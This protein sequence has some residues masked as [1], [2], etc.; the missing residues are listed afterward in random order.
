MAG[1]QID[2]VNNKIDFD[3]DLDTSIS[4]NTDDTLVIEAGGVNIASITAGE[5]AINEGSADV[6]FRVESNGNT[7]M[8]FVDGGN[9]VVGIGTSSPNFPLDVVSDSSANGIQLRG[10]SAD[11]IAQFSFESNDS[12]TTYSQLQSLSS[13][14]KVKTIANIPMSFHTNNSEVFRMHTNGSLSNGGETAPDTAVGLCLNQAGNDGN[15]LTFKSSDVGHGITA[16]AETD[17]YV[18]QR[19]L[20]DGSGGLLITAFSG[21]AVGMKME[22][23]ITGS[24]TAESSAATSAWAVD[25][26]KKNGTN[27]AG[28]STDDNIAS[29]RQSDEAQFI[30]K[31]DGELF[32]NQSATVGTYDAYEDAQLVRA[33]DLSHMKGVIDSKFD[34]F[35]QYN[36]KDL[37]KARLIGTDDDGNATSF[38]SLTGMSRLH[39]GAIWQQ[40]EATQRLTNAMYELA[41]VAVGEEKANE[42]LKQNEI[43]LLN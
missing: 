29:F 43:K 19:K 5:F 41:K 30:I 37:Q 16:L 26:R 11:N 18:E 31:G 42:I 34:K 12:G 25:A 13:E 10:R 8:L 27:V 35:V 36:K 6:D 33:Y 38:V 14:L 2:G 1:I 4:A 9:D 15:I 40:Y 28:M 23:F 32:S 39:N 21:S 20:S 7:H 3:D 24:N 22:A 17:T